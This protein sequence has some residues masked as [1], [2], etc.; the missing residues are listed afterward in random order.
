[1]AISK[2]SKE[3]VQV[4]LSKIIEIQKETE[5]LQ[6][7]LFDEEEESKRPTHEWSNRVDKASRI[8]KDVIAELDGSSYHR[9]Y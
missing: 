9:T 4:L 2:K 3:K 1:M 6:H 5:D 7:I 8:L